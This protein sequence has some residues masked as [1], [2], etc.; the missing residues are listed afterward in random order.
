MLTLLLQAFQA[1]D[2]VVDEVQSHLLIAYPCSYP[3]AVVRGI[4]RDLEFVIGDE[5]DWEVVFADCVVEVNFGEGYIVL[6]SEG[7]SC[8]GNGLL[9]PTWTD[10]L[11]PF[12]KGVSIQRVSCSSRGSFPVVITLSI[13]YKAAESLSSSADY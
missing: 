1:A 6:M 10:K 12:S 3:L 2:K 8:V 5:E 11:L 7:C 9:A 13:F 4:D